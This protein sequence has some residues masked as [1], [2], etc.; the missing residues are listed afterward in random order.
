[1]ERDSGLNN[2]DLDFLG[3]YH[4]DSIGTGQLALQVILVHGS[5]ACGQY[6]HGRWVDD[7][8]GISCSRSVLSRLN[9]LAITMF[10][11]HLMFS[12]RNFSSLS[13]H[14]QT[15]RNETIKGCERVT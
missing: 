7:W 5:V 10:T 13:R 3:I 15:Q 2:L 6:H 12:W 4:S 14:G 11:N 9:I 8:L 1:V